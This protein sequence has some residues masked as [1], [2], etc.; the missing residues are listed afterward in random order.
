MIADTITF[1]STMESSQPNQRRRFQFGLLAL[2]IMV[3]VVAVT[4]GLLRA[5]LLQTQQEMNL[6]QPGCHAIVFVGM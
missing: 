6:A 4:I 1:H 3:T 5:R 2:L